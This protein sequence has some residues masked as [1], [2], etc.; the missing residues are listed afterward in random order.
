MNNEE[1]QGPCLLTGGEADEIRIDLLSGVVWKVGRSRSNDIVLDDEMVSR[2]HA[3]IQ[4]TG[5]E[6]LLIDLGRPQ[7]SLSQWPPGRGSGL[8]EGPG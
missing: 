7:R 3:M 2:N 6:F 5:D 8:F 4:R 1:P